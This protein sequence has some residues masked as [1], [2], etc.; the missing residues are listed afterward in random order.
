[1]SAEDLSSFGMGAIS[2]LEYILDLRVPEDELLG[3]MQSRR[4]TQLRK[5]KREGRLKF[6]EDNRAESLRYLL[7][8]QSTSR[9]RRAE[10][11]EDYAAASPDAY[12]YIWR[13]YIH[14]WFCAGI[15]YR[16]R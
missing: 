11:G 12:S 13:N 1:M 7:M 14:H 6:I 2:R 4:R 9:D 16:R 8:L 10:R 3:R 15:L 5:L